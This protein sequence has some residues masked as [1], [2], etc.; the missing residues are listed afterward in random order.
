MP[1]PTPEAD[2]DTC[3]RFAA[4]HKLIFEDDGEV[5]FGRPCVGFMTR[6]SSYLDYSPRDCHGPDPTFEVFADCECPEAE[7][8]DS[9]PDAYHKH[10]C[11]AV[12]G[13]GDDAVAQLATWV[14]HLE[15]QGTVFV[16]EFRTGA[17]SSGPLGLALHS[18]FG[19]CVMIRGR[20]PS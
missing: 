19:Q 16:K 13:T 14:R 6:H 1:E 10:D 11:M 8:P 4:E 15:A 18:P 3:Q 7:P 20:A 2:R 9:V 5:G 17:E 12:L